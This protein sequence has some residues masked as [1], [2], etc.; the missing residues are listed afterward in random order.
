MKITLDTE[1]QLRLLHTLLCGNDW[2]LSLGVDYDPELFYLTSKKMESPCIEDV[3]VKIVED[4]G[5]FSIIDVE[6]V[7][8]PFTINLSSLAAGIEKI[9]PPLLVKILVEEDYD[10]IDCYDALQ[11]IVFGEI[12]FG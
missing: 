3:Y 4:G 12:L 7:Y 5:Q 8:P 9:P 1:E 11:Y 6:D 10:A 2:S